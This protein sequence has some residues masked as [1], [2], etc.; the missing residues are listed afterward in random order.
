MATLNPQNELKLFFDELLAPFDLTI[1]E[2]S[3]TDAEKL[4]HKLSKVSFSGYLNYISS[5]SMIVKQ[6]GNIINNSGILDKI[7]KVF[8]GIM[9]LTKTFAKQFKM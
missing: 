6:M 5:F 1:D 8:M 2:L 4:N 9:N 3:L 7:T